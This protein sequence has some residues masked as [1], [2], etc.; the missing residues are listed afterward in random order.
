MTILKLRSRQGTACQEHLRQ[1]D[2]GLT[3]PEL[4]KRYPYAA[5]SDE[6]LESS[7]AEAE[8]WIE[9]LGLEVSR[10]IKARA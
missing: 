3:F 5:L 6:Q 4:L 7:I 10:R 9:L 2:A 8:A 1:L